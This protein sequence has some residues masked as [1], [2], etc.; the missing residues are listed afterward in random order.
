MVRRQV[1]RSF[2]VPRRTLDRQRDVSFSRRTTKPSS[3]KLERLEEEAIV[4]CIL[5]LEV[6][7]IGAPRAMVGD[8]ANDLRAV[9]GEGPVGKSWVD[10]FKPRT[11]LLRSFIDA[12][13]HTIVSKP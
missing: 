2:A 4:A 11:N 9:R 1:C 5:E 8:M 6:R 10:R 13:V 7:G 3:E 12:A